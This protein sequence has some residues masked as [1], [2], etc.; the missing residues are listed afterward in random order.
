MS[1]RNA[2]GLIRDPII[3]VAAPRSGS[4]LLL[5]ALSAHPDLWSLYKESNKIFEGPFHPRLRGNDSH[6]L[7]DEDLDVPT[8]E[9]ILATFFKSVGNLE[10]LPFARLV[11]LRGRG[12]PWYSASIAALTRPFKR[13][14]IRLVEKSPRNTL[15]IPFVRELF[16][17]ARFIHLTRDAPANI[18]S[19]YGGW[20]DPLHYNVY[21]LPDGFRL[22]GYHGSHWCF[23]LQPGWRSFDGASV[24]DACA[25]Q[26][27]V[28]NEHCLRDLRAIS[29]DNV[30]RVKFEEL[31]LSPAMCL[32]E[33]AAWADLDAK[34][35]ARFS[36]G[37]PLI[38]PSTMPHGATGDSISGEIEA[39][40]PRLGGLRTELA[41]TQK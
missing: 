34:P 36:K 33:I 35:F 10:R 21:P 25:D 6:A 16:P 41:Y 12:R 30:L 5:A 37:L 29:P 28:C 18:R 15:R 40:L 20:Q 17:D 22:D 3:I 31:V 23:V 8:R 32:A 27:R 24:V 7:S 1:R 9:R 14:P 2:D 13:P 26:W 38:Q 4:S 11:P 19:L 39:I